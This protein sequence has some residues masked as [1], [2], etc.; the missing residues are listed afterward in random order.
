MSRPT[1]VDRRLLTQFITGRAARAAA[2]PHDAQRIAVFRR[3]LEWLARRIRVL[4]EL[5]AKDMT[6]SALVIRDVLGTIIMRPVVPQ[7]VRPT[8]G[9]NRNPGP[10]PP[11][12]TRTTVRI[13]CVSGGGGNRTPVRKQLPERVYVR[14]R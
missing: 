13:H 11:F 4:D 14:I 8:T 10:E 9:R 12:K 3:H 2:R 7:V 1:G 5:L 6:R